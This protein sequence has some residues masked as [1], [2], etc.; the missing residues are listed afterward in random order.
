MLTVEKLATAET[1]TAA[2]A[3]LGQRCVAPSDRGARTR[4]V[5][6]A[7]AHASQRSGGR[8]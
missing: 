5:G 3:R 1:A 8:G 4:L 6:A 2:T 7:A